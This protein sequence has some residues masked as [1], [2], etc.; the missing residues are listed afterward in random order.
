M[1]PVKA[2][3]TVLR[4]NPDVS[5]G[6]LEHTID[7]TLG[8]SFLNGVVGKEILLRS[9]YQA[10]KKQKSLFLFI[11]PKEVRRNFLFLKI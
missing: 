1:V 2:I 10:Y 5:P 4:S 6:I 7:Y 11:T 3:Q 8:K 9:G